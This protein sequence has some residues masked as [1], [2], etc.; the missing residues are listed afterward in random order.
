MLLCM[1]VLLHH[2]LNLHTCSLSRVAAAMH[3]PTAGRRIAA[4]PQWLAPL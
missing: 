3:P 4:A 2:V 1:T